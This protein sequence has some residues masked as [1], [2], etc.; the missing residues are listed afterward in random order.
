MDTSFVEIECIDVHKD[1][2]KAKEYGAMCL[3]FVVKLVDGVRVKAFH[4]SY[5]IDDIEE[6]R[7]KLNNN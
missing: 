5:L 1:S 6:E 2:E 7:V 3:P 4:G